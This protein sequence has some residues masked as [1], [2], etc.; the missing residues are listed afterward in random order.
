M[1]VGLEYSVFD[2]SRQSNPPNMTL[3]VLPFQPIGASR[4]FGHRA[5]NWFRLFM[6]IGE[7]APTRRVRSTKMEWCCCNHPCGRWL[8]V[9]SGLAVLRYAATGIPLSRRRCE[10]VEAAFILKGAGLKIH[11]H[12]DDGLKIPAMPLCSS[13]SG[14]LRSMH[15][16]RF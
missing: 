12:W 16:Q 8:E 10:D 14:A 7:K 6:L 11:A 15:W 13:T 9:S 1:D 2:Y 4:Q 5:L 3:C